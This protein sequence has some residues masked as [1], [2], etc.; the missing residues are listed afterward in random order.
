ME[1][2][3]KEFVP[4]PG[5]A[6]LKTDLKLLCAT[7]VFSATVKTVATIQEYVLQEPAIRA[8]TISVLNLKISVVKAVL[9]AQIVQSV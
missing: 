2:A 8:V 4:K 3:K 1:N 5:Y 7:T 6:R 9:Q